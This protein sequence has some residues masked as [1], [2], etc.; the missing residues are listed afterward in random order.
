VAASQVVPDSEDDGHS[1]AVDTD[2]YEVFVA[3]VSTPGASY[4]VGNILTAA[5]GTGTQATF[6]VTAVTAT[7]AISGISIA[8][9]GKYSVAPGTPN[10]VT[11]GSGA[12]A[13]LALTIA[14]FRDLFIGGGGKV[15]QCKITVLSQDDSFLVKRWDNEDFVGDEFAVAKPAEFR[16]AGTVVVQPYKVG[17]VIYALAVDNTG[18]MI[19]EDEVKWVDA[20]VCGRAVGVEF[21]YKDANDSCNEYKTWIPMLQPVKV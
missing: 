14:A 16:G 7:G 15:M 4:Q 12:G 20:N 3:Q 11:G 21:H 5:G 10:N 9:R 2:S 17:D 8:T 6:T 1:T 19:A 18:V 13:V